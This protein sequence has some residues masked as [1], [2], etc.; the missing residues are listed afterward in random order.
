M[1]KL[2][3]LIFLTSNFVY[4]QNI[5]YPAIKITSHIDTFYTNYIFEDQFRRLENLD[6]LDVNI[7]LN[8]QNK[9]TRKYLNR[10]S[11][12]YATYNTIDKF[13][14]TEYENPIK[15]GDY[16]FT[17]GYYNSTGVPALF[18]QTKLNYDLKLL[19]DPNFISTKDRIMLRAYSV[20]GNSEYLAYQYCRNG[21]DRTK[22]KI[23]SLKTK[24]HLDDQLKNLRLTDVE[25]RDNGFFYE[26]L[27][28]DTINNFIIRAI[29][30]HKVGAKQD[31]DNLIFKRNSSGYFYDILTTS[32]ERFLI[33]TEYNDKSGV[34]NIFY[35]DYHSSQPTLKPLLT[36]LRDEIDIIEHVNN[37]LIAKTNLNANTSF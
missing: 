9:L 6:S 11:A 19:V 16:Y 27:E 25:W 32:D 35:I 37:K 15:K 21:S 36:N 20:S 2:I 33:I 7:W 24:E 13:A 5:D 14:Y 1:K 10:A 30:Y 8:D 4:S 22:I 3:V 29:Y 17:Y 31:K 23:I 12:K 26:K 28:K 18:Y 34:Y